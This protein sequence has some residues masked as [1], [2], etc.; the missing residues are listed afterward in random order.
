GPHCPRSARPS[1]PHW[2]MPPPWP[3]PPPSKSKVVE[4]LCAE[5]ICTAPAPA[6]TKLAVRAS[7]PTMAYTRRDVVG[8]DVIPRNVG[9]LALPGAT[10]GRGPRPSIVTPGVA[11]GTVS[12]CTAA[13]LR[14]SAREALV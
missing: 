9:R 7:M 6:T 10:L 13:S 2:L 12:G 5:A 1:P 4:T 3:Q 11:G 8:I 14:F